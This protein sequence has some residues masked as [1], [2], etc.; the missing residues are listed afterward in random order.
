[1]DL[2]FVR[3]RAFVE[4]ARSGAMTSAATALGYTT[5]AVSQ[6]I[7]AL[8]RE[9]GHPLFERVGRGLRLT[10]RGTR[11]L[12]YAEHILI[13][14]SEAVAA[15]EGDW[16]PGQARLDI[17]LGVFGS[18]AAVAL[19]PALAILEREAPWIRVRS[20]ELDVDASAEAVRRASVDLALA[21]DYSSAPPA[22]A[23]GVERIVLLTEPLA[24]AVA[25]HSDLGARV[26]LSDLAEADWILA[27]AATRF[28]AASRAMCRRA[29][30][31]PHVSHEVTET[32]ACL[33]MAAA[34]LGA[35]PA[36]RMM[37]RMRP[38]GLRL[39][40]LDG[41]DRRSIVLFARSGHAA[42]PSRRLLLEALRE[43]MNP[44][45]TTD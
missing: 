40:D 24:V 41:A 16:R 38:D 19:G 8:E 20:V 34:G 32:G 9:L 2:G 42:Q 23:A 5:G 37:L 31:E 22:A 30:F 15:M 36:T 29:G 4:T 18:P 13:T 1:M 35:T 10:E 7:A 45:R 3:L 44:Y 21:C 14:E 17:R 25:D 12:A 28:G 39:I 6:Q 26:P 11:F 33:A 27:P 43:A